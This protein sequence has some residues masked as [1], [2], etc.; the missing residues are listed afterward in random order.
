M[1]KRTLLWVAILSFLPPGL[2]RAGKTE[3]AAFSIVKAFYEAAN[4]GDCAMAE[5]YFTADALKTLRDKLQAEGG[6][7]AFCK[8]QGGKSPLEDI[9]PVKVEVKKQAAEV[10]TERRYKDGSAA[11][12]TDH[13]VKEE[14]GWKIDFR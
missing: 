1:T 8:D 7:P 3:D 6:F 5:A 4:R 10:M 2:V 9:H 11:R 12:A 14:G 13:L